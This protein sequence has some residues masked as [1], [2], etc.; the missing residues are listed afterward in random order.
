MERNYIIQQG[1]RNIGREKKAIESRL[2]FAMESPNYRNQITRNVPHTLL[3]VLLLN[4][5]FSHSIAISRRN[6]EECSGKG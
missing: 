5:I 4:E 2:F 6:I 3:I 1:V